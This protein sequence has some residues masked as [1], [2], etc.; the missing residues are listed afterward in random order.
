[1]QIVSGTHAVRDSDH[2]R[3]GLDVSY[4]YHRKKADPLRDRLFN[5]KSDIRSRKL[6]STP[7]GVYAALNSEASGLYYMVELVQH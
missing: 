4:A 2:G 1:M 3:D 6:F 5:H 7:N